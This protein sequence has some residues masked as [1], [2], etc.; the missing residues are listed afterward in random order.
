M[1]TDTDGIPSIRLLKDFE[2]SLRVPQNTSQNPLAL[3]SQPSVDCN[4]NVAFH[5]SY[6]KG[7]P[8]GPGQ[9]TYGPYGQVHGLGFTV[10]GS[11]ASG[12]IGHIGPDINKNDPRELGPFNNGRLPTL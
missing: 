6:D 1:E 11:V 3:E 8:K 7:L 2:L 9:F 12:G 4:I 5:G 10:Y